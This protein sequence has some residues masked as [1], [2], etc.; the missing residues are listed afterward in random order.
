[1]PASLTVIFISWLTMHIHRSA[2]SAAPER[3]HC[4][5]RAPLS[6]ATNLLASPPPSQSLFHALLG[7]PAWQVRAAGREALVA[8]SRAGGGPGFLA[9]LPPCARTG[10]GAAHPAFVSAFSAALK[11]EPDAQVSSRGPG[12]AWGTQAWPWV[13]S[14]SSTT[15]G[16]Q[17][18]R[19]PHICCCLHCGLRDMLV[20]W[21]WHIPHNVY[22]LLVCAMCALPGRGHCG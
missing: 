2:G 15:W 12:V 21:S 7:S 14:T 5:L 18:P 10:A 6:I 22:L 9:L 17:G 4:A 16:L 13:E 1:M 11:Q 3:C 20:G 8:V 19:S